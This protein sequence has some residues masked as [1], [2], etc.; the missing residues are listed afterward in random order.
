M[1]YTEYL[2]RKASAEPKIL[3]TRK[4]TDASMYINEKRLK[5]SRQFAIDVRKGVINNT[6]DVDTNPQKQPISYT[7]Q[8]GGRVPDASFFTAYSGSWQIADK[9]GR[10]LMNSS[11]PSSIS[12]C[13]VIPDPVAPK[14]ASDWMRDQHSTHCSSYESELPSAF[15]DNTIRLKHLVGCCDNDITEANHTHP[16]DVPFA[17]WSPRA[18]KDAPRT[19]VV[20]SPSDARKVG[21]FHPRKIPYVERKHGNDLNVNPRRVP[22]K[23]QIPNYVIPHLKIND[24]FPLGCATCPTAVPTPPEEPCGCTREPI[25]YR[26]EMQLNLLYDQEGIPVCIGDRYDGQYVNTTGRNQTIDF[27]VT[28][29]FPS[30]SS[31]VSVSVY[32]TPVTEGPPGTFSVTN[33]LLLPNQTFDF[34]IL[35]NACMDNPFSIIINESVI[36]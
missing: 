19:L 34:S 21:N 6:V 11:D 13:V 10:V 27:L 14:S 22:T 12:G 29:V 18:P 17:S 28:N 1:S 5:S 36:P 20:S 23:Y 32:G 31:T 7:K 30:L 2:R 26:P 25:T 3:D 24:A 35:V 4:N 16:T 8:S 15:V 33:T 9:T